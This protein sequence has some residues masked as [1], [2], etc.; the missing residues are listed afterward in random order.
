MSRFLINLLT[1]FFMLNLPALTYSHDSWQVSGF[2]TQGINTTSDYN[3]F[4]D[5]DDSISTDYTEAGINLSHF[6]N[7]KIR[8]TTQAA[9]RNSN[10]LDEDEFFIDLLQLD[11]LLHNTDNSTTGAKIGRIKLKNRLYDDVYDISASWSTAQLP[12]TFYP[13]LT[14]S[15]FL[16]FEGLL[17]HHT[18][19]INNW[20]LLFNL[21]AGQITIDKNVL[22]DIYLYNLG[23]AKETKSE[24]G[25]TVLLEL[26][27]F[28]NQQKFGLS[29]GYTRWNPKIHLDNLLDATLTTK[30]NYY[31]LYASQG[32]GA[33]T[34][35]LEFA[36]EDSTNKISAI[37]F[38]GGPGSCDATCQAVIDV[39]SELAEGDLNN[40][41]GYF[42]IHRNFPNGFNIYLGYGESVDDADDIRGKELEQLTGAP[43]HLGY[44]K[45]TF[46][47]FQYQINQ[48]WSI[49]SEFSLFE[50]TSNLSAK[51]N[52]INNNTAKHWNSVFTRVS[53]TF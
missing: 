33:W 16:N 11:I 48:N 44:L 6:I 26:S 21:S 36:Y 2:F 43:N 39:Y 35:E 4:G 18:T 3:F 28:I 49:A 9:Y 25:Y 51:E 12:E 42:T 5:S 27:N 14:R 34:F 45:Q 53:F 19:E 38:P 17:L 41:A 23:S 15:V 31:V 1:L 24:E 50:G 13:Q 37:S 32:W 46:F 52:I 22:E 20:A 47:G 10:V 40:Y 30:S 7:D 8:F 29:Y